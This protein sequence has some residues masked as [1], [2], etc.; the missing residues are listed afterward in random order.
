[1]S[2]SFKIIFR[3]EREGIRKFFGDLEA[4]VM[5]IVW[6]NHPVTVKRVLYFLK[7]KRD[8]A[9]TTAMTAL[10][11]LTV[12]GYLKRV[13]QSHA[14]AYTPVM[15]REEFLEYAVKAITGGLLKDFKSYAA[16]LLA[17]K[18][19]SSPKKKPR[20]GPKKRK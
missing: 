4:E 7:K 18:K 12:K 13:K 8:Y 19:P 17:G 20:R 2:V 14:Y 6:A 1:M 16:P 9:Y 3:P 15:S 10:N 11:R 5:E